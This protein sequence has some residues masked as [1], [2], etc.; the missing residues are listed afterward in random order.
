MK[1]LLVHK[2]W[3]KLSGAEMY[4][5]DVIRI[6][7]QQGHTVKIFT[8]NLNAEGETDQKETSDELVYGYP[9]DYINGSLA[10][11]IFKLPELIYSKKNKAAI[12]ELLDEFKPDVVHVFAIYV[13][14]TPS[15][16]E[17]C[18]KRN[19][20]VV[21]SCNDYKHICTNYRLYHH[22]HV[23]TDC[24][25][26]KLYSSV[27]NN[28]CKHSLAFSIASS[29]EAYVHHFKN[30]FRKNVSVFC[31]ESKFMKDMTNEFWGNTFKWRLIGKPFHAP[32][33]TPS[34]EYDDY[35]LYI[36]RLSDEKG[37][38][39]LLNAMQFVPEAQ[40]KI[41]GAGNER[42]NLEKLSNDLNLKNVE[43]SGAKWGD[44][45]KQ[46]IRRARFIVIPS[47][48][49]E[50]FPY[51]V[52]ES[53]AIGKALIVSDKGG[54]PEYTFEGITGHIYPSDDSNRLSELIRMMW[55]NEIETVQKGKNAKK[56]ADENF[57]DNVFYEKLAEA[58]RFAMQGQDTFVMGNESYR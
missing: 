20:P 23:C 8:T 11:R 15:I 32:A 49:H 10:R 16:L 42:E 4:F 46:V 55:N 6:L 40:L 29:A 30:I 50:N 21:M 53:Y 2:F 51:V 14:L 19:I 37:I 28:C 12:A 52:T 31:F 5:H 13:T 35:L 54:L 45:A 38:N 44:E 33:Y 48:W 43:F 22:G 39:I 25:G 47:L 9:V 58:Y 57:N 3:K 26:G 27:L 7:K 24:K 18:K 41:V 17:A 34:Y 56:Y 36:G 1:I